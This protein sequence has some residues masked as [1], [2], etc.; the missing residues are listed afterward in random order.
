MTIPGSKNA[1]L[2]KHTA[3]NGHRIVVL[4]TVQS[5]DLNNSTK[6]TNGVIKI[7]WDVYNSN[8]K[9]D[10]A[11]RNISFRFEAKP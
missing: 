5:I 8:Q 3:N 1:Y 7:G 4:S 6:S 10:S 11:A 2:F 9:V